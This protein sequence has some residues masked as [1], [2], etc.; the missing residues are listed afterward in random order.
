M[1]Q[2]LLRRLFTVALIVAVWAST[3]CAATISSLFVFGDSLS[4]TGNVLN[5][6]NA[7]SLFATPRPTVPWYD[8]G[9]WTNGT[10][11][12]G[13]NTTQPRTTETAYGGVWHERLADKLHIARAT[14]SL[15]GGNN[16]AYGGAT[17]GTGTYSGGLS[18]K[19]IGNQVD[20]F[21]ATNPTI[22]ADQ[23][24]AVWGGGNDVRD[25]AAAANAT[26]D[27]IK[28]AATNALTNLS[29]SIQTLAIAGATQFLWP[30]LPPLDR[31]PEAAGLNAT[32]RDGL[33]Q[34]SELFRDD[35]AAA[36]TTLLNNN[37]GIEIYVLDVFGLFADVLAHPGN[38][39]YTN[40]TSGVISA[41][42]FSA[43]TFAPTANFPNMQVDAD[44]FL[45]WDQVHPTARTQDL[46][47][48]AAFR[49]IAMVP[50]PSTTAL[51]AS[52]L[53]IG[54]WRRRPNV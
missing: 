30:N 28:A 21:R 8:T 42:D 50:E 7:F 3:A 34:A 4:D 15:A 32:A 46:I 51:V 17:T 20:S 27:S 23:L 37:D 6:T 47:G 33:K 9:R 24:F 14:N 39:G 45:F 52:L 48:T 54:F 12:D 25:A 18:L 38:Y 26:V 43:S 11:N 2:T 19:N 10:T 40:I 22:E 49:M 36:V 1:R 29:D 5:R 13:S 31:T 16:W 44:K 41:G 35:Q 53:L